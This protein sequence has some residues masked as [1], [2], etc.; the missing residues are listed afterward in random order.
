M[1]EDGGRA[2]V[3]GGCAVAGRPSAPVFVMVALGAVFA[4]LRRRR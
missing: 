1:G 2:M 3:A 4:L